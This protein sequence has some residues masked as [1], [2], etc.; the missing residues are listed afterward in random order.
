MHVR[1]QRLRHEIAVFRAR[2][3]GFCGRHK[4]FMVDFLAFGVQRAAEN[5]REAENIID[6][7]AVSRISGSGL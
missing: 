4:H 7:T 6:R 5:P 2:G 1:I 3:D